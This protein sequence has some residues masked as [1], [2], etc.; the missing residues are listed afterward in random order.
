MAR[1]THSDPTQHPLHGPEDGEQTRPPHLKMNKVG[2][3]GLGKG[4]KEKN[5]NQ[6]QPAQGRWTGVSLL[7][8][9]G[10]KH[11]EGSQDTGKH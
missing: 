5:R 10:V 9:P 8:R 11:L 1:E 2:L 7:R 3:R 4:V 6:H